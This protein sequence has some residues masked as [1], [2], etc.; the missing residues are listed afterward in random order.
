MAEFVSRGMQASAHDLTLADVPQPFTSERLADWAIKSD[1]VRRVTF[2]HSLRARVEALNAIAEDLAGELMLRPLLERILHRCTEIMDCDAGSISSVDEAAG[3]YRKE[4]DIGIRCQSGQA[5]PLTEGMTGAVVR[6]RGPVWF[7]RYEDVA[8]GHIHPEDRRALKGVIGVPLEWRGRIIGACVVFSRREDRHFSAEDAD[9]LRLFG[10][11]AAIALA[12]A[13]THEAAEERA[14]AQAAATERARLLN[15][16]HECLAQGLVG[17]LQELDQADSQISSESG[18]TPSQLSQIRESVS[19][20]VASVRR[21]LLGFATSPLEGRSL[22]DVLRAELQWAERASKW[23]S[24]LSVAGVRVPL[25]HAL[26]HEVLGVAQEAILNIVQHARAETVRIGL[27]YDSAAVSLLVQ[28]DGKGFERSPRDGAAG[29]GL[30]RMAARVRN[31]G[32]SIE[33]DSVPGWGTRVRARFPYSRTRRPNGDLVHVLIVDPVP[34]TRAGL[35]R[36][37]AWSEPAIYIAGEVGSVDEAITRMQSWTTDVVLLGPSLGGAYKDLM[38]QVLSADVDMKT[39]VV[40]RA[41]NPDMVADA[42]SAGA[43]GWVEADADG[44]TLAHAV[45][46]A[47]FGRVVVPESTRSDSRPRRQSTVSQLTAREREVRALV[48]QGLTDRAIANKL[49]IS[50]KTAEK[51]VGAILRK[52]AM[53]S[54]TELL[55]AAAGNLAR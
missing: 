39:V 31:V 19:E 28:D 24:R 54:R 25:E 36:L 43:T 55:A 42:I 27:V 35:A 13:M 41:G 26:A 53:R 47:S 29:L 6:R 3:V 50:V 18:V 51:H 46:A 15:D 16:V 30:H 45:V 14:R 48:E 23:D 2:D 21:T 44:P 12:N 22:E 38:N 9:L 40:S 7:E 4:A 20:T 17:V 11:H 49:S 37:L 34:M 52:T 5:F 32:G 1:N 8:G 10:K 33:I